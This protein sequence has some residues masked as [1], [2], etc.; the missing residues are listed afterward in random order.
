M[1]LKRKIR[2][3]QALLGQK[4]EELESV[5]RN[6]RS[7][8]LAELEAELKMYADESQRLR[9]QLEDVLRS[10]EADPE[11][12]RAVEQRFQQQEAL[13]AQLRNENT[14]LAMAFSSKDQECAQAREALA[15]SEKKCKALKQGS[16]K[17]AQRLKR[18]LRERIAEA[19]AA[20][21]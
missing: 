15:E 7:T 12:M 13:L 8:K 21:D 10:R 17:E 14:T 6:M 16:G 2:E 11:Q 19:R 9:S 5:R 4:Q 1:N 18:Q 20:K 3:Q